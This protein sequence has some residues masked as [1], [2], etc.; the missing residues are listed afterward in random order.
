M[1]FVPRLDADNSRW[2]CVHQFY[3]FAAECIASNSLRSKTLRLLLLLCSPNGACSENRWSS[4]FV[5]AFFTECYVNF[6]PLYDRETQGLL[7]ARE[8]EPRSS[9]ILIPKPSVRRHQQHHQWKTTKLVHKC[10][11]KICSR[12]NFSI[13]RLAPVRARRRLVHRWL[14]CAKRPCRRWRRPTL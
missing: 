4:R 12:K 6:P 5:S 10:C 7:A 2:Q 14:V 11:P 3:F 1:L 8:S 13:Q 9:G